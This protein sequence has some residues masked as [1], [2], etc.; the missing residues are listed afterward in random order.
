MRRPP[1]L[2]LVSVIVFVDTMLFAAIIPLVPE[3]TDRLELST[4]A[5]G[6]LVGAYGAGAVAAGI[7]S[8]YIAERLGPRTTVVVGLLVLAAATGAFA[9]AESALAL[10]LARLVRERGEDGGGRLCRG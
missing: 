9:V 7:P 2:L 5:A 10:G 6:L 1:I 8:G 4:V 3:L